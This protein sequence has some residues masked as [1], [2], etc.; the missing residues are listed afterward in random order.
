MDD[1][2]EAVAVAVAAM[3]LS[4]PLVTRQRFA[5]MTGLPLGVI[6]SQ[7]DRGYWPTVKVGRYLLIN[8]A[9]LQRACLERNKFLF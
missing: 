4:V 5:E 3:S 7:C 1:A 8:M 2:K 6:Q 9:S